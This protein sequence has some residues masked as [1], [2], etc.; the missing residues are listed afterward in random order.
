M[1]ADLAA[2]ERFSP[3]VWWKG[4]GEGGAIHTQCGDKAKLKGVNDMDDRVDKIV[5]FWVNT[6]K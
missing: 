6:M 1:Q 2:D 4:M 5:E 3:R